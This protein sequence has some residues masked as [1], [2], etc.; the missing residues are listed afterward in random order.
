ME[1]TIPKGSISI[2][3]FPLFLQ[4]DAYRTCCDDFST[5]LFIRPPRELEPYFEEACKTW[6]SDNPTLTPCVIGRRTHRELPYHNARLLVPP[7]ITED[8]PLFVSGLV[9]PAVKM[10]RSTPNGYIL[11]SDYLGPQRLYLSLSQAQIQNLQRAYFQVIIEEVYRDRRR[12]PKVSIVDNSPENSGIVE[13]NKHMLDKLKMV[14]KER[15]WWNL[16]LN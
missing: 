15:L 9:V 3:T 4:G 12:H 5:A 8:S 2:Y 6:G 7:Y 1:R 11:S 16:R 14:P 13:Q 10:E